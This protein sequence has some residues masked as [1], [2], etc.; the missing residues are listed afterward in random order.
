VIF[1]DSVFLLYDFLDFLDNDDGISHILVGDIPIVWMV[2]I[3]FD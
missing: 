2:L 3:E 1:F